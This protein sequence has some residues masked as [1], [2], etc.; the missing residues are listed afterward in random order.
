M[1]NEL[2]SQKIKK[3]L[4]SALKEAI[5]Y[6][7]SNLSDN[8]SVQIVAGSLHVNPDYLSHLFVQKTGI[9]FAAF[10]NQERIKQAAS[11]L[12][13][14]HYPIKQ[15][16]LAVGYNN[17]SYFSKEF[18]KQNHMTPSQYRKNMKKT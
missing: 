1:K 15:I 14:T 9:H 16:A 4:S 18:Q 6:T 12:L 5:I 10:I 17:I 2:I 7:L 3:A 13:H 8:L 11:L